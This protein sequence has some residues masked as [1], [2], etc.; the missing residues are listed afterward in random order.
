[1]GKKHFLARKLKT[2]VA[3]ETKAEKLD[4]AVDDMELKQSFNLN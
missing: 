3:A 1:M 2:D 4:D